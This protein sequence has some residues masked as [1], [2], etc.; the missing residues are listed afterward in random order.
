MAPILEEFLCRGIV[1]S[2]MRE[3][4]GFWISAPV[5][6]L[7]WAAMHLNIVQG[8][9]AFLF[10]LFLAFLYEKF[11][12]LIV[13]ILCHGFFNLIGEVSVYNARLSGYS[14]ETPDAGSMGYVLALAFDAA[15]LIW[16]VLLLHR[17]KFPRE[18]KE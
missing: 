16:L 6:S 13:P 1:F 14:A 2:K 3:I 11:K 15:I 8:I 4:S 12:M 7:V 5:S 9:T 18:R 10:G 17:S